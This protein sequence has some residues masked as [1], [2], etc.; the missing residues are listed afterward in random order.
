MRKMFI[1]ASLGAIATLTLCASAGA[2]PNPSPSAP[3][4]SGTGCAS[5]LSNNPNT[6]PDGFHQSPTGGGHFLAVGEAL[7]GLTG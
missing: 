1:G 7:C 5:V 4:H 6:A 2:Q 3:A